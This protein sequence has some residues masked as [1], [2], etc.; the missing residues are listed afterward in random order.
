MLEYCLFNIISIISLYIKTL[1]CDLCNIIIKTL[2]YY[3]YN[4][5]RHWNMICTE[6]DLYNIIHKAL[7]YDLYGI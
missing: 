6:Y 4:I 1:E 3:L 2:E 5:T 7:E